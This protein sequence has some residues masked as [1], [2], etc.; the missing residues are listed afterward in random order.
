MCCPNKTVDNRV[1]LSLVCSHPD[2]GL[3]S[4]AAPMPQGD[5][6]MT[7]PSTQ[8]KPRKT[9][10]DQLILRLRRPSGVPIGELAKMLDWQEHSVR[11]AIAGTL[12]KKG[13]LVI[14]EK[15]DGVRRYRL[16]GPAHD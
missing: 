13:H 9:K 2:A 15:V 16:A 6:T 14:S 7:I 8:A 1:V 3:V 12:R 5:D 11:G 10:L 4:V